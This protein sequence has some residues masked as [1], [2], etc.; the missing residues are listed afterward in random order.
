M[1]YSEVISL[2]VFTIKQPPPQEKLKASTKY[3]QTTVPLNF[4]FLRPSL[5]VVAGEI[6]KIC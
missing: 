2:V 5:D 4:L 6:Q 3:S 1:F